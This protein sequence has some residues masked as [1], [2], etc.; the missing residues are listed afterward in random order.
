MEAIVA[1]TIA[2]VTVYDMVKAIDP[3]VTLTDVCLVEKTGGRRGTYRRVPRDEA[4]AGD[5]AR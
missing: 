2:L 5:A 3:G 1:V 4:G